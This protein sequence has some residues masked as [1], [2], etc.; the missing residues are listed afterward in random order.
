MGSVGEEKKR[1]ENAVN[2]L[3]SVFLKASA[4]L[5]FIGSTLANEMDAAY[6]KQKSPYNIL[7][8]IKK[9]EA[10]LTKLSSKSQQVAAAE[11]ELIMNVN[12]AL[13]QNRALV[14]RMQVRAGVSVPSD[15]EDAVYDSVKEELKKWNKSSQLRDAIISGS[16]VMAADELN[17][18]F[19]KASLIGP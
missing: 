6:P 4:D 8:R 10:E 11:Q 5:E 19:S 16:H 9:L 13:C 7:N 2:T 12:K 1:A 15:S 14:R 18:A 17:M 3:E